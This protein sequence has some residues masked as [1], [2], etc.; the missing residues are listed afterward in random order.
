[1]SQLRFYS[2][3]FFGVESVFVG[4]A[5]RRMRL[6]STRHT[7]HKTLKLAN[8]QIIDHLEHTQISFFYKTSEVIIIISLYYASN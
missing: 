1:M 7:H 8:L 3:S 2:L 5:V 6:C 4:E